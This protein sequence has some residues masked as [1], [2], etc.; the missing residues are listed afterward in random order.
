MNA[1]D[2]PMFEAI[3]DKCVSLKSNRSIRAVI[4][5]GSGRA[6]CTGLDVTSIL[7]NKPVKSMTRLLERANSNGD[8]EQVI[9][10]LAQDVGYLWRD[11]PVPVIA[12]LHGMCFGGGMQIALG[13]D[14]RLATYVSISIPCLYSIFCLSSNALLQIPEYL[15][16]TASCP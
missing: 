3:A 4:L 1:L 8:D 12:C 14:I 15:D 2:M 7:K 13:A 5:S 6:F 11:L 9:S 10:N 16:P